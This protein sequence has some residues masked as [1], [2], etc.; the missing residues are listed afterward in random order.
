MQN[1]WQSWCK[2]KNAP[3]KKICCIEVIGLCSLFPMMLS[4]QE[5][6]YWTSLCPF[7][8]KS[9]DSTSENTIITLKW[10]RYY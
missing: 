10:R 9:M 4:T 3:Q 2:K 8:N 5:Q 6:E 7:V 1:K